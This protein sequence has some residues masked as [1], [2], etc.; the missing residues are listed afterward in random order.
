MLLKYVVTINEVSFHLALSDQTIFGVYV[1]GLDLNFVAN[2]GFSGIIKHIS[3]LFPVGVFS[4]HIYKVELHPAQRRP[5]KSSCKVE[6]ESSKTFL[7]KVP[8]NHS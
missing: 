8:T 2:P 1:S 6:L 4:F 7:L 3:C 5:L